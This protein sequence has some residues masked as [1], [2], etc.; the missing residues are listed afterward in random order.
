MASGTEGRGKKPIS[1]REVPAPGIGCIWALALFIPNVQDKSGRGS[2]EL[3][4]N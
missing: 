2:H 4:N 3:R 1:R